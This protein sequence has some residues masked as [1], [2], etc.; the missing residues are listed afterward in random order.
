MYIKRS[1]YLFSFFNPVIAG[2]KPFSVNVPANVSDGT[3]V[4]YSIF[5][6]LTTMITI[7]THQ[8]GFCQ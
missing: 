8:G 6:I 1:S 7:T 2:L 5:I 3:Y 4:H